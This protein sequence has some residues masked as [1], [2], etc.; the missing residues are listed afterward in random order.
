VTFCTELRVT[1]VSGPICSQSP[2]LL[3]CLFVHQICMLLYVLTECQGAS[4]PLRHWRQKIVAPFHLHAVI[5]VTNCIYQELFLTALTDR[6]FLQEGRSMRLF[7]RLSNFKT[8]NTNFNRI[9]SSC[10]PALGQDSSVGIATGYGLDDP[11]IECRW[12]RDFSH[13][14]RPALRPTERPVQ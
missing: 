13:T 7:V 12:G 2:Q 1:P 8:Q 11:G 9:F 4:L 6:Q 5:S 3:A 10:P 14:S